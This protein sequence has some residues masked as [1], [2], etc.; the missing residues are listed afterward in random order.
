MN[1]MSLQYLKQFKKPNDM[2]SNHK[3]EINDPR[4]FFVTRNNKY[5]VQSPP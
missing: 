5:L 1:I 2:H 3:F 4:I